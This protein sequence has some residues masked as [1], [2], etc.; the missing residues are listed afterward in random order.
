VHPNIAQLRDA[1]ISQTD[2]QT[3]FNV[4]MDYANAGDLAGFVRDYAA[5]FDQH[6]PEEVVRCARPLLKQRSL[7]VE[8]VIAWHGCAKTM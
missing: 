2:G 7:L 6:L 4:V 8:R 1:F 3:S 5:T